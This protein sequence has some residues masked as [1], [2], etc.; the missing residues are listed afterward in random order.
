MC[1]TAVLPRSGTA[2]G[3]RRR[4]H[5]C[6]TPSRSTPRRR[7]ASRV[8]AISR[9]LTSRRGGLANTRSESAPTEP[10]GRWLTSGTWPDTSTEKTVTFTEVRARY[11][12]LT[13]I[14]E[15]GNRGP[16]STAAEINLL[17]PLSKGSWGPTINFPLVPVAAALLPGNRLLT[18]SSSSPIRFN[19]P[20]GITQTSILDLSTGTVSPALVVNT[21]HDMFCPGTSMLADGKIMISGGN[22]SEKTTLYNPATNAWTSGPD[23]KIPRGYQS[24]VTTST[25]E[26]FTLGGSWSGGVGTARTAR[27]GPPPAAGERCPMYWSTTSSPTTPGA[28]IVATITPGCL[29]P[30]VAGCSTP[31]RAGR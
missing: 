3:P 8:C 17:G 26:V 30:P 7:E 1:S 19:R 27:C 10:P 24:N 11:V 6:R 21:G 4:G 13:A 28:N 5:R 9:V 14:T 2:C 20:S 18:W 25:G 23:M 22:N 31:G 12:R 16:W 29:P 15:A